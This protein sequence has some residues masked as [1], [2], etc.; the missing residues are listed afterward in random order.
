MPLVEVSDNT[1]TMPKK[2][3][4]SMAFDLGP[5]QN[6]RVYYIAAE[7]AAQKERFLAMINFIAAN[8]GEGRVGSGEKVASAAGQR[9]AVGSSWIFESA[10]HTSLTGQP[11]TVVT[12]PD[13]NNR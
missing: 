3:D 10:L 1:K 4:A 13:E 5:D 11:C 7:T 12:P 2:V 9:F 8:A 6:G